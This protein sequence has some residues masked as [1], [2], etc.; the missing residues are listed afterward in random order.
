M[1]ITN[2][3]DLE[4][5]LGFTLDVIDF[6]RYKTKEGVYGTRITLGRILG[7]N[8]VEKLRKIKKVH[9]ADGICSYKYAPEIKYSY[10]Y[11]DD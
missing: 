1:D 7:K 4:N 8:E 9:I 6:T 2:I 3:I 10:F 11:L 5:R